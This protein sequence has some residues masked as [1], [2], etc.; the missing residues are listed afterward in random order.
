MLS[1]P[2]IVVPSQLRCI[3]ASTRTMH[4]AHTAT[5]LRSATA[6]FARCSAP[7][8]RRAALAPLRC[9]SLIAAPQARLLLLVRHKSKSVTARA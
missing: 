5:T 3:D 8:P 6:A 2:L 7:Q 4:T 9:T 1:R